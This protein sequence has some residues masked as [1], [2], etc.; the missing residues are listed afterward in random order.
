ML[1][2][3]GYEVLLEN[4]SSIYLEWGA[5]TTS[6][7]VLPR[8]I[9]TLHERTVDSLLDGQW[10]TI[11][12][13]IYPPK[14]SECPNC[15]FDS[16]TNRSS[17]IYKSGGPIPFTNFSICP[18]CGG[19]GR[20]IADETEDIKLRIYHNVDDVNTKQ[21]LPSDVAK[22]QLAINQGDIVVIGYMADLPKLQRAKELLVHIDLQGI[23]R[24]KYVQAAE[25]SNW[26]FRQDRYF[27]TTMKRVG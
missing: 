15:I 26:G 7:Y 9:F 2:E 16:Q 5:F 6:K 21:Y 12:Q 22:A 10:A 27:I 14:S 8:H 25:S 20:S 24:W 3:D 13:L 23:T 4:E 17:S 1:L 11:C 18:V 19:L